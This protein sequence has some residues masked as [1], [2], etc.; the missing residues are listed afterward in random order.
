MVCTYAGLL[1]TT[2]RVCPLTILRCSLQPVG[3][4]RH[5]PGPHRGR[6]GPPVRHR[7][8]LLRVAQEQPGEGASL[9]TA[10][11]DETALAPRMTASAPTCATLPC[12][13]PAP[14]QLKMDTLVNEANEQHLAPW[15]GLLKKHG[16]KNTPLSPFLHKQL[17]MVRAGNRVRGGRTTHIRARRAAH[18]ATPSP[19]HS[20]AAAQPPVR[21][22]QRHR[23]RGLQV[24]GARADGRGR[25]GGRPAAHCAGHLPGASGRVARGVGQQQQQQ[26]AIR[27]AC[28]CGVTHLR[29]P[30]ALPV[31][32]LCSPSSPHEADGCPIVCTRTPWQTRVFGI[33]C[34]LH[35]ERH[36][37]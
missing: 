20:C 19:A 21:G 4:G 26:R 35:T 18:H 2:F 14:L 36:T 10:G 3:P 33:A 23:G 1:I 6:A 15:L 34:T 30:T 5:G 13:P 7:D 31:A 24:R 11:R 37:Q 8:Q 9:S 27:G 17:L 29:S 32:T 25:E 28:R 12:D 22:R 16:I